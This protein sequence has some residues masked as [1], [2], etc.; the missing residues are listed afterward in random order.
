M[1]TFAIMRLASVTL[2]LPRT[3]TDTAVGI[4]QAAFEAKFPPISDDEFLALGEPGTHREIALKVRRRILSDSLVI[5]YDRI[6]P[7][8]SLVDDLGAE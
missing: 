6:Y 5:D 7:S 2:W 3:S 4:Q 8:A 1:T